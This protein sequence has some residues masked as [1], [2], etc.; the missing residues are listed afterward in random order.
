R[1]PRQANIRVY[2][3]QI[4]HHGWQSTHTVV[5]IVTDDKP[6]LVDS[7][8]MALNRLGLGIHLMIHPVLPV[9]RNSKGILVEIRARGNGVDTFDGFIHVEIDRQ[10]DP[11]RLETIR[12]ELEDA[13]EDVSVAVE[14]WKAMLERVDLAL[15]DL[16]RGTKVIPA[17]QRDEARAFLRWTADNHFT[18]LGY[19]CYELVHEHGQ[20]QLRRSKAS[21]LGILRRQPRG[22]VSK[23][24]A[25]LSPE[26]KR[27]ARRPI[28]LVITKANSR[29]KVHRHVYLDYIGVKR[30]NDKGNVIGEHRFLGLFTSAAY[31]RN[32][33]QIPL[34]RHKVARLIK[35]SNLAPDGHA[36]KAFVNILE[37]YPRDELF[38]T[39]EDELFDVVLETLHLQERQRI[40]LFLRRDAFARFVSCLVYIPRE[41]YNTELRHR[42][43][44]ILEDSLGGTETEFQVHVSES[45]LARIQYIVRTPEGIAENVD[46]AAIEAQLIVASRTWDE[47][48]REGLIDTYGEEEGNRLHGTYSAS[49][50][51]AYQENVPTRDAVPDIDR[52]DK[53]KHSD[54]AMSLFRS[55][56][57]DDGLLHFKIAQADKGIPLSDALPI[58]ENMG[59]RVISER[60]YEI[61][62][63][64]GKTYWLHDFGISPAAK[65]KID[66]DAVR[67]HFQDTFERVWRGTIENDGFNQLVIGAGLSWRQVLV[68]R[69]YCKYLIQIGIPFSQ[70]YVE[71]TLA[72]NPKSAQDLAA[73]FDVRFDPEASATREARMAKLE[74]SV[75]KSLE[76]V[77]NLDE[78]RILRRYLRLVLAT[79]R[80]NHFQLGTDGQRHKHY[81]SF[82]ID[83]AAVPEMPLPRPAFE[84]FVYSPRTEGVHLR[85][86]L[87]ARGGIRW[88]DRREDFRTEILGLMKAQM[89]KNGVIVPVGAKGGFVVKRPPSSGD[90]TALQAEVEACYK[91]LISGM[92]DLTD[93]RQ[94]DGI[95]TP[96]AVVRYDDDD[97]YLVVAADKGTAIFS[98]IANEISLTY[99]HWLG[100]AFASGGSAGYDHKGMGITARGAWESIKRHFVELGKDCQNEPFTAIGIGDMSGDLFGN[101]TLLSEQLRLIAAFDHR[102]I[103]ID[104]DPDPTVSYAERRRL[105]GLPCSSWDDY[106]LTK[107]SK[108]GG[109]FPRTLKSVQLSE[110]IRRALDVKAETMTPH[111]LIRAILLAPVELFWNGGV[112]TYVKSSAERHADAFDRTNDPVRVDGRDLRCTIIGEG[113]NFGLTQR[114]RIEFAQNGGR[115]NTDFIDNSAGV[116]C[117][118][119]EVNIKI[120]LG[121]VVD[122]GDMTSIQRNKLLA[123]MADEVAEL[124][125]RNNIL[126]V[127]AI[128]LA[129]S[130]P[131][132]LLDTQ[133]AFMR[134]LEARGRLNREFELLPDEVVLAERRQSGLGLFRPEIAILLSYAKMELSDELL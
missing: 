119:H 102:N 2:N 49:F 76:A 81:L 86:G 20:D 118:D 79:S 128:S 117:S 23:S 126:Q 134:R 10:S 78:D 14:D 105:I 73:L 65:V 80:T 127:Q 60:P 97:P 25:A 120:L 53:L 115:L 1:Q 92:L 99:G 19:G 58:L 28:P 22:A 114:S 45:I 54:L 66:L 15:G 85:G 43:Q 50:P 124:V 67:P 64:R 41:R 77:S 75:R 90:R 59:L 103:F 100:D 29:S 35:R 132:A 13:L 30:F 47:I 94:G 130:D 39:D 55:L 83:P 33:R 63:P 46:S 8:S 98:D 133:A 48:L 3:P 37:T 26:I 116:D 108:G 61:A 111:D 62:T 112:G 110:E 104:P 38:Q 5:E 107:I 129:E 44:K 95:T 125:L 7:V 106:D 51:L 93:N 82:K 71:R 40:R 89:V 123:R 16:D 121:A 91:T 34:L 68:L 21:E 74:A 122:A 24:F 109:V 56:A 52:L 96:M 6:F 42:F 31:N 18:F 57:D 32:P 84:I 69:A 101:G 113:G 27:Q 88:S 17:E 11:Q 87:V 72:N 131:H 12:A 4:E 70:A 36:G 9:K